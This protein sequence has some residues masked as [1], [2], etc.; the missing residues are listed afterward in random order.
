M[1]ETATAAAAKDPVCGMSVDP[2]T[3]RHRHEHAG[4][5]YYFCG[6][7]CL[8]KFRDAPERFLTPE[9]PA[10]PAPPAGAATTYTCPM[11][12]EI[13]QDRPGICPKCGMALEP[14]LV[15]A[16]AEPNPELR[17]M[18]R[19]FWVGL[20]LTVPLLVLAMS[21]HLA[22]VFLVAPAAERWIELVLATPVVL[23][24][25]APFFARAWHSLT[26]RSLN[27]FT[28]IGLG[29]GTAYLYSL[30]AVLAPGVFP[31]GFR[32]S[33]G[34]VGVYFEA[35]AAIT[36]LVL[37]GQV[38]E[39]KA[40][41]RTSLAL[42]SLLDLAPKTARRLA[43]DGADEEVPLA[44]V[45]PDDR[46]RVRPGEKIPVDGV[47][48]D[49][50]GAVDESMLTGEPLPVEKRPGDKLVGGTL[51]GNG[52]FVMR[53]ERV[54]G[55]TVLAQIV[56]MVAAAQRSRAPIQRIADRVAGWFV[57]V[58]LGI[59][60]LAFVGWAVW[61]PTPAFA[62]GLVAAVSVLIIACPCALGLATPMA[63]MVGSGRGAHAGVLIRDA[64]ALER[65]EKVDTIVVD[66]TGTLTLGKPELT[67]VETMPGIDGDALLALA[68][69][70]E[71]AS[72]HP[73]AAAIVVAAQRRGLDLA[74]PEDFS[75]TTGKGVGG[76]VAGHAVALGNPAMLSELGIAVEPLA[77]P[78]EERRR[79]GETV[80]FVAVDGR[81]AGFLAVADP[82]RETTR[83][84]LDALRRMGLSLVM[85]TGDSRTTA[86]AIARR[87]AL[88]AFEAELLPQHKGM[89]VARLQKEG[90]VVAMAGDGINDAPA[91]AQA[92]VGIAIGTGA[93]IAIESAGV[94]LLK[95]DLAGIARAYRLSRATMRNIR[96]NLFLAFV[97]NALAIPIA[98]GVLYP[99]IGLLLSPMIAA[100]TM[101]LSS[102]SVIGNALR[103]ARAR[104]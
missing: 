43:A 16:E 51:N 2:A 19:R 1:T 12:P 47:V 38:L 35:A 68:A 55:D 52:S 71:R 11:H 102:V 15:A 76:T 91:L 40:R 98:A 67:G 90:H 49:G 18:T 69:G 27:M 65:F 4:T 28:L 6:A 46:L 34:E 100:A 31:A 62:Y 26:N 25:G 22:R 75:A 32:G 84:A 45:R 79:D 64:A 88:D 5:N 59:A 36:V 48:L 94:T 103:L 17:D 74:E 97:Y 53:A 96:Q 9:P 44:A 104:I 80:L 87:L 20:V 58:V 56:Q 66:K 37:L 29:T 57:P 50:G 85:L 82:L 60:I 33:S 70:L 86:A 14:V 78:A 30:V 92:D 10:M 101:S 73:L 89:A 42:R 41:D 8:E 95:G 54:G 13:V 24:C 23:G 83:P 77:A 7:H 93:D 99:A 63:I 61:G 81:L 39:L 3:A 21:A 72:E